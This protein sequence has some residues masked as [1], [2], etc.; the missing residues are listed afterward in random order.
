LRQQF[1]GKYGDKAIIAKDGDSYLGRL[2]TLSLRNICIKYD[3]IDKID[4]LASVTRKVEDV[5]MVMEDNIRTALLNTT[6]IELIQV[7]CGEL[8]ATLSREC[9]RK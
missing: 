4:K 8:S 5:K 6:K 2:C 9:L 7:K 1:A 3:N